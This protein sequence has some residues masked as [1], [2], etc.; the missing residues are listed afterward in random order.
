MQHIVSIFHCAMKKS[1]KETKIE[2]IPM[3]SC[4]MAISCWRPM[5]DQ[6]GLKRCS[7]FPTCSPKMLELIGANPETFGAR[8]TPLS[9]LKYTV[10]NIYY[11]AVEGNLYPFYMWDNSA[12]RNNQCFYMHKRW[13]S[14]YSI[15]SCLQRYVFSFLNVKSKEPSKGLSLF[16][17]VIVG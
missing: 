17:V 16:E 9:L 5:L 10:S 4:R 14:W 7:S 3:L 12:L 13:N 6:I 11:L 2:N 15:L 8:S 1:P